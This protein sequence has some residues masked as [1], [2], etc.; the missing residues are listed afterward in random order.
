M[1]RPCYSELVTSWKPGTIAI[2][3]FSDEFIERG[4]QMGEAYAEAF[5]QIATNL[6][7]D[8]D[9]AV[10]RGEQ[11]PTWCTDLWERNERS[12]ANAQINRLQAQGRRAKGATARRRVELEMLRLSDVV[13]RSDQ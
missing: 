9:L 12:Y 8:M 13:R 10:L 7:R 11:L 3:R 5:R 1:Q 6:R 2:P 4:R